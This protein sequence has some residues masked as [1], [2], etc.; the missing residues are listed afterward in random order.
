M[1]SACISVVDN[2][3]GGQ[4]GNAQSM[5]SETTWK[6]VLFLWYKV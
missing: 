6:V 4:F 2:I 1:K 3:E 5:A